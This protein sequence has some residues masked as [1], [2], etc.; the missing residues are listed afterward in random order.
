MKVAMA[1]H[2]SCSVPLLLLLWAC[3]A[4]TPL[5]TCDGLASTR[6][7]FAPYGDAHAGTQRAFE[8]ADSSE[9]LDVRAASEQE[10]LQKRHT[11][12]VLLRSIEQ[13]SVSTRNST[14]RSRSKTL[15]PE[16]PVHPLAG[17]SEKVDLKDWLVAGL[18]AAPLSDFPF[19]NS[20]FWCNVFPPDVYAA[21][22]A[23]W[24][25]RSFMRQDRK[26]AK[27]IQA[28]DASHVNAN[29]RFKCS[30]PNYL[31]VS[32]EEGDSTFKMFSRSKRLWKEVEEALYSTEFEKALWEKLLMRDKWQ[33]RDFRVQS[34]M[35][36]FAIGAHPDI[37]KKLATLMFYLPTGTERQQKAQARSYGTCLHTLEQFQAKS[38][39]DGSA[40]CAV[41]F[42]FVPNA[43]YSFTVSRRS[44]H[45]AS[46]GELG[47]RRTIMLNWYKKPWKTAITNA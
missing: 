2:R 17:T 8:A 4:I 46:S 30:L 41:K 39:T 33:F 42:P 18:K 47:E 22:D 3:V 38:P 27:Y 23:M 36:G 25:P 11:K 20:I 15:Y 32:D 24:I 1:S 19:K 7:K 44:Y 43:G 45:S 29:Q 5:P 14:E 35:R 10:K 40:E 6:Q 21:L 31:N 16:C 26:S 37:S 12:P 34:D 28:Q 9:R 13:V